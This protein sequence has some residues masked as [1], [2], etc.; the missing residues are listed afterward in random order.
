VL[1]L[2]LQDVRG[3]DPLQAGLALLPEGIL[4]SVGS[5]LSGRLTARAG[6][7]R[8][9][10]VL[11][12]SLGAAGL[13]GLALAGADAPY[14]VLVAPLMAAGAG[15]SLTMPA[16][17]TAVVD[18][19]PSEHAGVA[20]GVLN[21]ARQVGGLVGV[22][23]LGTLVAGDVAAGFAAALGVSALAFAAA[24]MLTLARVDRPAH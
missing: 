24:A 18:G 16:A 7:P 9:T 1:T 5:L 3:L 13:A 4:V 15:M 17:T 2:L 10:M 11:G 21:A 6:T 19:A 22:A 20:A 23:L 12:L 8:R 14:P